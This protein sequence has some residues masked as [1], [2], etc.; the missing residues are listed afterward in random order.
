MTS[1]ISVSNLASIAN[2][3][4]SPQTYVPP[5]E[6]MPLSAFG[7]KALATATNQYTN[8]GM[9]ANVYANNHEFVVAFQ[10]TT[11]NAQQLYADQQILSGVAGVKNKTLTAA[12][13]YLQSVETQILAANPNAQIT[14]TG[15][16]LGG[17]EAD[18]AVEQL[19]LNAPQ[20]AAHTHVVTFNAPALAQS[21]IGN[22]STQIDA[23]NVSSFADPVTAGSLNRGFVLPGS[24]DKNE[25]YITT[26]TD[27]RWLVSVVQKTKLNREI[28]HI[29]PGS[30]A[31]LTASLLTK[32]HSMSELKTAINAQS[33]GANLKADQLQS[34]PAA[35]PLLKSIQDDVAT[36]NLNH[37]ADVINNWLLKLG[38]GAG[39]PA[40]HLPAYMGKKMMVMR[41]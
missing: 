33:Q 3:Q 37:M 30:I 20:V 12:A 21:T 23:V 29:L 9:V 1:A 10:G 14:I 27:P 41:G 8:S 28:E 26:Q 39:N 16:S 18:Y 11:S 13:G 32:G 2:G 24:P 6:F 22:G 15:H 31:V 4:Y 17:A 34:D 38:L 25:I 19:A 40:P 7:S 5:V 35:K 36:G